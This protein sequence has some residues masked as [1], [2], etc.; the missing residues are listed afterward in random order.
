MHPN[1]TTARMVMMFNY[2][3]WLSEG[4]CKLLE[5]LLRYT[6][7]EL[8]QWRATSLVLWV[9]P[10]CLACCLKHGIAC[11]WQGQAEGAW[12]IWLCGC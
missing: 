6:R 11:F 8:R 1:V 4:K 2:G 10:V 12:R 9:Q 5:D 7:Q 3:V